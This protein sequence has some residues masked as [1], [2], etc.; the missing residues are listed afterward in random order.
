M[1]RSIFL[2]R[3]VVPGEP[4]WLDDDRAWA[5][6]LMHVEADQHTCGHPL[7]ETLDPAN[8]SAYT[9]DVRGQCAACLVL[10]AKASDMPDGMMYTVRRK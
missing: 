4:L 7:S 9:V 3:V 1:P 2:G 6:A 10:Q 5:L 8:E